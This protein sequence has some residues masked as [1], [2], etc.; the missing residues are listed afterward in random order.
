[1]RVV[2]VPSREGHVQHAE[3]DTNDDLSRAARLNETQHAAEEE[4]PHELDTLKDH[5]AAVLDALEERALRA[6]RAL[7]SLAD[8]FEAFAAQARE[9]NTELMRQLEA[10]L[11]ARGL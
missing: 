7:A 2:G 1:M 6:E 5:A 8:A 4:L 10:A 3:D 11:D 9:H